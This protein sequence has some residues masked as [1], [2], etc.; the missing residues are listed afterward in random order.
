MQITVASKD[1]AQLGRDL[2]RAG[3]KDLKKE[4]L[5][6]L[7]QGVKPIVPEIRRAVKATPS[8]GDKGR[9]TKA[10]AARPRKLRDATA[11][12]VQAKVSLT[13]RYAGVRLRVDT[14]HFPDGEKNL[15]KYLEGV[16]PRW[17]S[18]SWGHD[19]WKTQRARPYFYKTI[20]PYIPRVQAEVMKVLQEV[21]DELARGGG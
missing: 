21:Q 11:R 2:Q 12:G 14:R 1:L 7:R 20:R 3:K 6:R 18:P 15:P 4:T 5:K 17:R 16:L 9:S 10:R 8:G 19:P 13:G